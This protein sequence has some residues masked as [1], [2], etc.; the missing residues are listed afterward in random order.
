MVFSQHIKYRDDDGNLDADSVREFWAANCKLRPA[1]VG[2]FISQPPRNLNE[3]EIHTIRL[4]AA[5]FDVP[6]AAAEARALE[7][8]LIS[9]T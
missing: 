7:L 4:L 1:P 8:G 3:P 5:A 9:I 6:V 2:G